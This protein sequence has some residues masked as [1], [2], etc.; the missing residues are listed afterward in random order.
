LRCGG[1]EAWHS[2][3]GLW[4]IRDDWDDALVRRWG[5]E[6]GRV[7][8]VNLPGDQT[9]VD[10]GALLTMT[11]EGVVIGAAARCCC[12]DVGPSP[13]GGR[14]GALAAGAR[15]TTAPRCP[16]RLVARN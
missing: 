11:G 14:A 2:C 8:A 5:V 15:S 7:V 16:P 10:V 9:T 3:H 4:P 1:A 6:W 13:S 12:C